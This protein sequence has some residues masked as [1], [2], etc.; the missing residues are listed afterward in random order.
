[1]TTNNLPFKQIPNAIRSLDRSGSLTT[2]R[3]TLATITHSQ[4]KQKTQP[5]TFSPPFSPLSVSI[6]YSSLSC[7]HASHQHHISNRAP[8][9]MTSTLPATAS[10]RPMDL[11]P[12]TPPPP[13]S[14]PTT[15]RAHTQLNPPP[16]EGR[17]DTLTQAHF[18]CSPRTALALLRL[19]ALSRLLSSVPR[20]RAAGDPSSDRQSG[21]GRRHR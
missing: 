3:K 18:L 19:F 4:G 14:I 17:R 8:R 1:M 7:H 11:C 6:S 15:A 5:T 12:G 21:A 16:G 9:T 13:R 10:T 20:L 2:T